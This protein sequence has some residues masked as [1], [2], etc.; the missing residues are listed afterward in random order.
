[1]THLDDRIAAFA[2]DALDEEEHGAVELHLASCAHCREELERMREIANL[3]PDSLDPIT[4]PASL[5]RQILTGIASRQSVMDPPRAGRHPPAVPIPPRRQDWRLLRGGRAIRSVAAVLAAALL[6]AAVVLVIQRTATS[7]SPL[8]E[9]KSHVSQAESR[10]DTVQVLAGSRNSQAVHLAVDQAS[11]GRARL[12]IGPN[13]PP[14]HGKVYELWLLKSSTS[15]LPQP[16]GII[17]PRD[18]SNSVVNLKRSVAG[19]ATVAVTVEP[20]PDGSPQPT[21]TPFASAHL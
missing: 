17:S 9:W 11:V 8:A 21:T 12:I 14:D 19:Y 1:M 2:L 6:V 13:P 4:P 5:R 10:G 16:V 15:S 20:G 18:A 3:L 7:P